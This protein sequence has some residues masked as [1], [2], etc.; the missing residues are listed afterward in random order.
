MSDLTTL[1]TAALR[2]TSRASLPEPS[3]TALGQALGRVTR[4]TPEATLLAR[5][6]LAGLYAQ[7]GQPL[8]QAA[9]ALLTAPPPDSRPVSEAVSDL[10]AHLLPHP[11]LLTELLRELPGK[12]RTLSAQDA[13]LFL[14]RTPLSREQAPLLW[15][16]LGEQGRW[17]V[18][19]HPERTRFDPDQRSAAGSVDDLRRDWVE[20]HYIAPAQTAAEIIARWPSLKADE[21]RAA[22]G[23]VASSIHPAD[24]PLLELARA[25][26]LADIRRRGHLLEGHL[27]G[28]VQEQ[29]K[30]ALKAC[31]RPGKGGKL[32]LLESEPVAALGESDPKAK[33]K[34]DTALS[35]VLGALP[36]PIMLDVAGVSAAKLLGAVREVHSWGFWDDLQW[37]AYGGAAL[38]SLEALNFAEVMAFWPQARIH[39]RLHEALNKLGHAPGDLQLLDIAHALLIALTVP[40]V[41]EA[42]P[43]K[44]QG[45]LGKLKQF[46]RP[47]AA[48]AAQL[49]EL[50][51]VLLRQLHTAARSYSY[52]G[53]LAALAPHLDPA[54]PP[55]LPAEPPLTPLPP[56]SKTTKQEHQEQADRRRE[57]V[58]AAHTDLL[59]VLQLRRRLR[60]V[61]AE[62]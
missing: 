45:L 22:L 3:A 17:L 34:Q 31:A 12:N 57:E 48:P 36:L 59:H 60:E 8:Q 2:G 5:A 26:K 25:D 52:I 35:R 46:V 7:A 39:A 15:P 10:L 43:P 61:L 24:L 53:F 38:E 14:L 56:I 55:K 32:K 9:Q 37:T 50:A 21:R 33:D 44:A 6:A 54:Q 27:A 51:S 28:E 16:A 1:A 4:Q 13:A 58:V 19:L 23:V 62:Q 41:S 11:V 40:L 18:R 47:E 30:A 42:A 29:V 49:S 20:A